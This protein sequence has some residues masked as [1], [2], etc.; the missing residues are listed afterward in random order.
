MHALARFHLAVATFEASGPT[1]GPSPGLAERRELTQGL[2]AEGCEQIESGLRLVDWPELELRARRLL[3]LFRQH[4]PT[5][6]RDLATAEGIHVPLQP[7]LRDIWHD[8]V[9]FVGDEVS[10][11]VDFGAVRVESVSGDL[12]RL[13]GS[14]LPNGRI[15]DGWLAAEPQTWDFALDSYQAVRPLSNDEIRLVSVFDRS[16]AGLSGMNWLTWICVQKRTFPDPARVLS[17]LDESL[18]RLEFLADEPR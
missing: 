18:S 1:L 6:L 5:V 9:L 8:H 4:A 14:L 17:R 16:A 15:G 7:C 11:L 10:G 2:L 13:L 12:A 3:D